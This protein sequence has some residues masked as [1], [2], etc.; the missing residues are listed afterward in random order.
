M[1]TLKS[2]KENLETVEIISTITSAYQEIAKMRMNQIRNNVLKNRLFLEEM[3]KI[4][5]KVKTAYFS[6]LKQSFYKKIGGDLEKITFLKKR[7]GAAVIFCSANQ[8]FFGGL[9]YNIG[10][11]LFN[12]LIKRR[13]DLIVVGK[14]GK[15]LVSRFYPSKKY[16]YF[17]LNDDKPK[18]DEL[19]KI[20]DFV[21]DYQ[22]VLVFHGKFESVTKQTIAVSEISGNL[23]TQE[24]GK[25]AKQYLFEP[26]PQEIFRFFETEIFASLL[27]HAFFE[28]Q[29]AKFAARLLAMYE[30]TEKAK[31]RKKEFELK[32][33]RLQKDIFN[34]KQVNLFSGYKLWSKKQ[35]LSEQ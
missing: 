18:E 25:I 26:S 19:K 5:Q 7:R 16:F 31:E 30:A 6:A 27:K 29:L 21:K 4:Y 10:S 15:D 2:I 14:T 23:P 3:A 17:D 28:H 32:K 33:I 20:I 8:P 12:F 9:I 1:A 34:K 24:G 35:V 13:A 11:V 22:T